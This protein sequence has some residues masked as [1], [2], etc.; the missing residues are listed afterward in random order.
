VGSSKGPGVGLG[1]N[2]DQGCMQEGVSSGDEGCWLANWV[3]HYARHSGC[4]G[5]VHS[6]VKFG[7]G[8]EGL[9]NEP[10][11]LQGWCGKGK[12]HPGATR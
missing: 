2:G 9:E 7:G 5:R 11:G 3:W 12:M 6:V 4:W 8:Q 10:A 1:S